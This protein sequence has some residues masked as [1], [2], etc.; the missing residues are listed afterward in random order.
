[1]TVIA[2]NVHYSGP[3]PGGVGQREWNEFVREMFRQMGYEWHREF[4]AKHFTRAGAVEYG[5]APRSGERG[6]IPPQGFQRSYTGRKLRWYGHT[7]P[8]VLTGESEQQ[9]RRRD[10]RATATSKR[11]TGRVHLHAPKLNFRNPHSKAHP[12]IEV[13]LISERE[14]PRLRDRGTKDLQKSLRKFQRVKRKAIR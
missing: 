3:A 8:N 1:M 2:I 7:R 4:R 6:N 11:A 9:T 13:T 5:Y 10:V 12:A 14:K